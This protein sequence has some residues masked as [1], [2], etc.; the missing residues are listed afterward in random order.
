MTI[1]IRPIDEGEFETFVAALRVPFG[2]DFPPEVV[3]AWKQQ[4]EF[5]RSL[6]AFD[7]GRIVGGAAAL[8]MELTVPGGAQVPTAGVTW[9][10]VMPTH[11]R[12]GI[13]S[14][15]IARQLDDIAAGGE[16]IAVLGSSESIIYGRFGYGHATEALGF[17][18]E[19]AH[20]AFRQPPR[21][22]GRL[23]VLDAVEAKQALPR[24][25]DVARRRQPG[26]LARDDADWNT[27]LLDHESW[28]DGFSAFFFVV[29]EDASRQP[30][31]YAVYRVKQEWPG[32]LASNVVKVT[33]LI[34]VSDEVRGHLW[35]YLLD[36]D[37]VR[38]VVTENSPVDEPLRW[39]LADPRRMRLIHLHDALWLRLVDVSAAL[40]ARTYATIDTLVLDVADP[41]RPAF[42]GRYRVDGSPGGASCAPT[43]D[44]ADLAI[45]V[46]DLASTYLGSTTF[47]ELARARRVVELT[48]G[49]MRR[50]DL[51]FSSTPRP[52]CTTDV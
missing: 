46:A 18:I 15:L 17:E 10:A 50:A 4:F 40:R 52:W 34:A 51:M 45:D 35:R 33:E 22:E 12:R 36:L 32:E 11:R 6:A 43:D 27:A 19:R 38:T 14:M 30:D 49:A 13:A 2:E 31:G 39:L 7:D 24:I 9:I 48:D 21:D 47:S 23:R 20:A 29:H 41:F 5:D 44:A 28:R 42:A 16:P 8:T 25:F 1:E 3:A 37:L 26:E